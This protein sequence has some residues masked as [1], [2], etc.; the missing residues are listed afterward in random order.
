M[1]LSWVFENLV[2]VRQYGG[3]F[4]CNV[5]PRPDGQM[6]NLFYTYCSELEAWMGHSK[7]SLIGAGSSPGIEK[8]NVPITTRENVWYLHLLPSFKGTVELNVPDKPEQVYILRTNEKLDIEKKGKGWVIN[9][10][11]KYRTVTDD[12]ILV[13][14]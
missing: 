13:K 1:P 11:E 4:L 14:W 2:H 6:A 3:N 7:E 12:V 5:G 10:P 8:S 9:F